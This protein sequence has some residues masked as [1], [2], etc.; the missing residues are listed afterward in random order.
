MKPVSPASRNAS[1]AAEKRP[2]E[3]LPSATMT[4][5][6]IEVWRPAIVYTPGAGPSQHCSIDAPP[7]LFSHASAAVR[8]NR[9]IGDSLPSTK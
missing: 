3:T 9:S 4:I 1:R 8:P 5:L 7:E 6:Q 2:Y